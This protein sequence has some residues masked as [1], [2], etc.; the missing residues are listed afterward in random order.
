MEKR[1]KKSQKRIPHCLHKGPP[2]L[3][4]SKPGEQQGRAEERQG[5][6]GGCGGWE[7]VGG[8]GG[9]DCSAVINFQSQVLHSFS[10]SAVF[11][12]AAG[13]LPL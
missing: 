13:L 6:K 2:S 7:R 8:G 3:G 10:L 12:L 1:K 11:L 4:L 5:E 9:Y